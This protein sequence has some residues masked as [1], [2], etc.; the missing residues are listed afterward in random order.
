MAKY[1]WTGVNFI[2]KC[3]PM[4]SN[5]VKF[6]I[7]FIHSIYRIT[8]YHMAKAVVL[9]LSGGILPEEDSRDNDN[10]TWSPCS[11]NNENLKATETETHKF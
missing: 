1:D 9:I 8:R 7:V 6:A 10:E 4:W 3:D 5:V 2:W 11:T